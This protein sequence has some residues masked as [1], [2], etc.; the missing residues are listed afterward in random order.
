MFNPSIAN[1]TLTNQIILWSTLIIPWLTLF[2]MKKE[3]IRRYLPA[4]LFVMLISAIII[5]AGVRLG[6]WVIK[7]N[8]FPLNELLPYPFGLYPALTMWILK[9]TNGNFLKYIVTNAILDL[10]F[11]YIWQG[12]LMSVVTGIVLFNVTGWQNW[13]IALGRAILL[14]IFQKLWEGEPLRLSTLSLSPHP[15]AAKPDRD[16]K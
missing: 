12:Y 7:E 5:D 11:A 9:F 3:D 14:Y 4:A 1:I 10:G 2:F 8:V 6:F 15:A 13:L 16:P